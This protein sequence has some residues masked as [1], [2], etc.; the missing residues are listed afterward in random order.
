MKTA[1][2]V[3]IAVIAAAARV[4]AQQNPPAATLSDT[5]LATGAI[6]RITDTRG[7]LVQGRLIEVTPASIR[8]KAG[9]SL[10]EV[11]AADVLQIER[12]REDSVLNG[13]LIGLG[14]GFAAGVTAAYGACSHPDS[15]CEAIAN[16]LFIPIGAGAGLATGALLDRSMH[17]FDTVFRSRTSAR[18]WFW[19]PVV[20]KEQKGLTITVRF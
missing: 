1:I 8:V 14:V 4:G 2:F 9:R 13:A 20:S 6:V 17:S 10:K 15:E 12:R 18:S 7:A 3:T 19:A 5:G 16:A 11:R